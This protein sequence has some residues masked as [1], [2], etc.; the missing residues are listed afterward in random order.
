MGDAPKPRP[1][2]R[3][4]ARQ[5][6]RHGLFW[7]EEQKL[8]AGGGDQREA[9]VL[10]PAGWVNMIALTEGH[11]VLLVRQ[12][13]FGIGALTLEIPGGMIDPGEEELAAAQR[14]LLEETGYRAA[15]WSRLGEVHPNPAFMSNRC[16]TWLATDLTWVEEPR[17]DGNEEIRVESVP[18]ATIPELISRGEISHA[19]V[20][21]AFYLFG[22]ECTDSPG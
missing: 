22:Q 19:L 6:F 17:G 10:H 1:W 21:A 12:W 13:R 2:R 3:H 14:E 18:L 7:L 9:L 11:E 20:V 15:E 4:S 16:G 5:L 8:V